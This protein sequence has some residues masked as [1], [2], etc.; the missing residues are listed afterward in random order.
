MVPR[1]LFIT[2]PQRQT[3]WP[4]LKDSSFLLK[5][6]PKTSSSPTEI[7]YCRWEMYLPCWGRKHRRMPGPGGARTGHG[8]TCGSTP[9]S[10]GTGREELA[11]S[12]AAGGD[13]RSRPCVGGDGGGSR[14]RLWNTARNRY[15]KEAKT[16]DCSLCYTRNNCHSWT[17]VYKSIG[18]WMPRLQTERRERLCN[19]VADFRNEV[20]SHY[21]M[22]LMGEI[23]TIKKRRLN[24]DP[25]GTPH[26]IVSL[27]QTYK[28]MR[29]RMI[30][31]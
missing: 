15:N 18:S 20:W 25:C 8:V 2:P 10:W 21:I 4:A 6:A 31:F 9:W 17:N 14:E 29:G 3:E 5:W 1:N 27:E 22:Y 23:D 11:W 12:W 28:L 30:P 26:I 19:T 24:T 13:H 7:H 16:Q